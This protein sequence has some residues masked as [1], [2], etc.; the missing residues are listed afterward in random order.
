MIPLPLATCGVADAQEQDTSGAFRVV[1][2]VFHGLRTGSRF[3]GPVATLRCPERRTTMR[4]PAVL[5]VGGIVIE[6]RH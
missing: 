4:G 6:A 1:A 5:R 3:C 2:A